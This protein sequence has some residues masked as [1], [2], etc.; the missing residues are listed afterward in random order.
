MRCTASLAGC[1]AEAGAG[2]LERHEGQETDVSHRPAIEYSEEDGRSRTS[3]PL[4]RGW[5][6]V[7]HLGFLL[8]L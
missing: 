7:V 2:S 1:A 5:P 4:E 3:A 8:L 6:G